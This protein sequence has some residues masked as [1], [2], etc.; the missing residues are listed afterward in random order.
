MFK[1]LTM[2]LAKNIEIG[3]KAT[4]MNTTHDINTG[5]KVLFAWLW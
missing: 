4:D 3:D 2:P 5:N 1:Y